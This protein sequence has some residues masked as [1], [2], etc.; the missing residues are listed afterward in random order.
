M[1]KVLTIISAIALMAGAGNVMATPVT[2]DFTGEAG[3]W[4]TNSFNYTG[5]DGLSIVTATAFPDISSRN[6]YL[7]PNGLG[8]FGG[9]DYA[10]GE[11][12]QVDGWGIDESIIFTFDFDVTFLSVSFENISDNDDFVFTSNNTSVFDIDIPLA[13]STGHRHNF[14]DDTWISDTF[15]VGAINKDDDF[16][17]R[18]ITVDVDHAPVPEPATMLL[19]GTGL[20]G[21]VGFTKKRGSTHKH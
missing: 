2:F 10:Q 9:I 17:I 7:G 21:L 16:Y 18:S 11:N 12:F 15:E 3:T 4:D 13:H 8:V 19:F 6:L 1:K 20:L 5:S 14:T